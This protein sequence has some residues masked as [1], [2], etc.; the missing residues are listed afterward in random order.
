M[1]DPVVIADPRT[2]AELRAALVVYLGG[3]RRAG[4]RAPDLERIAG[5]LD[6]L[7]TGR[8]VPPRQP[9][10][11]WLSVA[12]AARLL[13]VSDRT[14]R[15]AVTRGDL[16]HRRIGRRVLIARDALTGPDRTRADNRLAPRPPG[17]HGHHD[18]QE[19][20]R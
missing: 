19:N 1:A 4:G 13:G 3:I 9:V 11:P 10:R 5:Q 16:E 6:Q 18:D 15:R 2:A 20:T 8:P 12:D 17:R 14:V 7:A